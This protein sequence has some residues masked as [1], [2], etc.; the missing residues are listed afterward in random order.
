MDEGQDSLDGTRVHP[1]QY[2]LAQAVAAMAV[3]EALDSEG[4]V[5]RV[6]DPARTLGLVVTCL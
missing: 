1:L 4:A 5:A 6:R 3:E 2:K